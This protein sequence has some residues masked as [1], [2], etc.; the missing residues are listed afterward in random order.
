[1]EVFWR[2]FGRLLSPMAA[3][4]LALP[5]LLGLTCCCCTGADTDLRRPRRAVLVR[6]S[7]N[8]RPIPLA[9]LALSANT[10]GATPNVYPDLRANIPPPGLDAFWHPSDA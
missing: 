4:L 10:M 1:M 8:G 6:T 3:M 9:G 7:C 2:Y 5:L